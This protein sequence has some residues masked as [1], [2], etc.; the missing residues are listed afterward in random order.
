MNLDIQ[1]WQDTQEHRIEEYKDLMNVGHI[2]ESEFEELVEDLLDIASISESLE[3]EDDKI[4]LQKAV[5]AIRMF[6]GLL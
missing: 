4:K 2:S 3:L 6:A 5:D 1:T